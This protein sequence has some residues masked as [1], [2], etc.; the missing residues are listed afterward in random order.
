MTDR[1]LQFLLGK[2][3]QEIHDPD[4]TMTVLNY[5]R[6]QADRRGTKEG[7]AEGDCGACTV[8]IGKLVGESI[9]YQAVNACI[10]FLPT[11]DGCQLITVED[12]QLQSGALHRVQQALVESHATQCGFC[13]PGFVMSMFS[14]YQQNV[15]PDEAQ[16]ELALA[17]NLCRCTGYGP[18]VGAAKQACSSAPSDQFTEYQAET[19]QQLKAL[20][21]EESLQITSRDKSYF[22]PES[23]E[24]LETLYASHP[25]A[26]LLSGGTDVG[27]WVTKQLKELPQ[28]IYLDRVQALHQWYL[29]KGVLELGAGMTYSE[30]LP[31]LAKH[32][33]QMTELVSRIG[34]RQIRNAGTIGGNIANG[35]PIGDMPPALIVLGSSLILRSA[36]GSREIS[37]QEFFI[38]YGKQDL[39]PGEFIE[40]IRIPLPASGDLFST[41][42]ISKRF[43]QDISAVCGAF[44]VQLSDESPAVITE[45][46]ICF[47]GMAGIPARAAAVENA[48]Q[49]QEWNEASILK[50]AELFDQDYTP[51]SDMRASDAYRLLLCKNLLRRF[52]LESQMDADVVRIKRHD[53]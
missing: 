30:A 32:L 29:V 16:I 43:D 41:Y 27:L 52:F 22:A 9:E 2:E 40:K 38:A 6:L 21:F 14:L 24:E 8:V 49:G 13:T 44:Y 46:K 33:P 15:Q 45:A 26:Q 37:L 48:L 18:I 31:V 47:G 42:K 53:G 20:Q 12:L 3:L 34:S 19:I 39:L 11:L 10:Q 1:V 50:A 5:L 7:C 36:K 25:D 23:L 51:L 28:L 35:S 4:P 17:G